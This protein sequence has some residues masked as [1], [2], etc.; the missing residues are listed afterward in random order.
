VRIRRHL[1]AMLV[2]VAACGPPTPVRPVVD[3]DVVIPVD[4]GPD[5]MAGARA[6]GGI[7]APPPDE[8][9]AWLHV[10]RE[11]LRAIDLQRCTR[12][13]SV[14]VACLCQAACKLVL[15]PPR[16][17]TAL[18][19]SDTLRLRVAGDGR[20]AHCAGR[21]TAAAPWEDHPCPGPVP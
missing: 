18:D 7:A 15:P 5:A 13:G 4:V 12:T 3:N 21:P 8:V 6:D 17:E 1:A 14:D 20:V 11:R 9:T 16:R 2:A 10:A 19:W